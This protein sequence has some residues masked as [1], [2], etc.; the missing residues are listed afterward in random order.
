[1]TLAAY[2]TAVAGLWWNADWTVLMRLH[3]LTMAAV[4]GSSRGNVIVEIVE[5]WSNVIE[6]TI[7]AANFDSMPNAKLDSEPNVRSL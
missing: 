2:C 1:M 4:D 6:W 3:L 7:V 5:H